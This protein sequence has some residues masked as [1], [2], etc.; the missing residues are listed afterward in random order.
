MSQSCKRA[1]ADL[2]ACA[3]N[4]GLGHAQDAGDNDD[5]SDMRPGNSISSPPWRRRLREE[6][7]ANA[8]RGGHC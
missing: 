4:D 7:L 5:L 1:D 2:W 6:H 3:R 8:Q